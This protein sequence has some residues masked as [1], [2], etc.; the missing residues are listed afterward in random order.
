MSTSAVIYTLFPVLLDT[1][2]SKKFG[3]IFTSLFHKDEFYQI[4]TKPVD[5]IIRKSVS[6]DLDVQQVLTKGQTLTPEQMFVHML[7]RLLPSIF[8]FSSFDIVTCD[9]P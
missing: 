4:L 8:I 7:H 5:E 9:C 2:N 3:K 6:S 1:A